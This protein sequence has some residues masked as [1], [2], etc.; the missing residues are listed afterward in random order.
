MRDQRLPDVAT[1]GATT[2]DTT[3][4]RDDVASKAGAGPERRDAVLAGKAEGEP[5]HQPDP[6]A[7]DPAER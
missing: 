4:E 3:P 6:V 7:P 1:E 2:L 5:G